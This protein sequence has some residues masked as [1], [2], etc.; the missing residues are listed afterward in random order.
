MPRSSKIAQLF[1][2]GDDLRS[3]WRISSRGT[4]ALVGPV[5]EIDVGQQRFQFGEP[6]GLLGEELRGRPGSPSTSIFSIAPRSQASPPGRTRRWMSASSAVSVRRGSM[7][8]RVRVGVVGDLLDHGAGPRDAVGVPR[9]LAEEDGAVGV[10]HVGCGVARHGAEELAVDPELAGLLLG[11]R[12]GRVLHAE[13]LAGGAGVAAGQVVALPAAAVVEDRRRRRVRRG[14]RPD[15][16]RPRG[17]RCPSRSPRSC[18]RRSG[19]WGS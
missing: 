14:P 15:R 1:A 12:V 18:R 16:P 19:A 9:V 2:R 10:V 4:P 17:W 6:V 7:T 3:P 13:G 5:V 11:E 8:I